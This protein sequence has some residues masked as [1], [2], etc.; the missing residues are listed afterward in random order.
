M[1]HRQPET[2][3]S[4]GQRLRFGTLLG[5]GGEGSVFELPASPDLGA[6][7]YHSA[8][9]AER[10]EVKRWLMGRMTACAALQQSFRSQR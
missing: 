2:V 8:L 7:I 5:R 6:K 9:S 4:R 10:V 3:D 1:S